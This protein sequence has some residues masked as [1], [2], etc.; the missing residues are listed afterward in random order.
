[1]YGDESHH[2]ELRMRTAAHI[3]HNYASLFG[4]SSADTASVISCAR[5][6]ESVGTE[7]GQESIVTAADLLQRP[8]HLYKFV[9]TPGCSPEIYSP[10]ICKAIYAPIA[11]AFYNPGHYRAVKPA[12]F[13]NSLNAS[14]E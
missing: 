2:L 1:M 10:R 6:I 3:A 8:V 9:T 13:A 11:I 7:A 5:R 14:L 12:L 4:I